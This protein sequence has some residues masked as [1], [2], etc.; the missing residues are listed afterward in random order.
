MADYLDQRDPEVLRVGHVEGG[1]FVFSKGRDGTVNVYI[2]PHRRGLPSRHLAG[3]K[4]T[5]RAL[6][7]IV[8]HREVPEDY[9]YMR[10][11]DG[12]FFVATL[13]PGRYWNEQDDDDSDKMV[14]CWEDDCEDRSETPVIE[15]EVQRAIERNAERKPA[16]PVV[17]GH[18]PR[19]K[20]AIE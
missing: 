1:R 20:R 13:A 12:C 11:D 4:N 10:S 16:Q 18:V 14:L 8:A 19:R 7:S 6:R 9:P 5:M 15:D 17:R 3:V 2:K